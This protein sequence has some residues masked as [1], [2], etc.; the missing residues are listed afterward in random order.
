MSLDRRIDRLTELLGA[1]AGEGSPVV[2]H[3]DDPIWAVRTLLHVIG[4]WIH[5]GEF[6]A[7]LGVAGLLEPDDDPAAVLA[8]KK[9][10]HEDR[11]ANNRPMNL[12]RVTPMQDGP[13][14]NAATATR[15]PPSRDDYV[16]S[17]EFETNRAENIGKSDFTPRHS[18]RAI[19]SSRGRGSWHR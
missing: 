9:R 18:G 12:F 6:T 10:E 14:P 1:G 8:R 19:M 5:T 7:A 17:S 4:H 11:I 13:L 16:T 2:Q 3:W 15:K